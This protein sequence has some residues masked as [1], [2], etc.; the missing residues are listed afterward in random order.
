MFP[1]L[2]L[3]LT[4][5]ASFPIINRIISL[6]VLP[7]RDNPIST[8]VFLLSR[9]IKRSNLFTISSSCCDHRSYLAFE[10]AAPHATYASGWSSLSRSVHA[11]S[12][13]RSFCLARGGSAGRKAEGKKKKEKKD[14]SWQKSD[15]GGIISRR[16]VY[17][18]KVH[19]AKPPAEKD[20]PWTGADRSDR[21]RAQ[22]APKKTR[23][24]G[25]KEKQ[26]TIS[27]K[28]KALSPAPSC[29]TPHMLL[30]PQ[31]GIRWWWVERGSHRLGLAEVSSS[32]RA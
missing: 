23:K 6:F 17:R 22:L 14:E 12:P 11:L 19:T 16:R 7:S 30:R 28:P 15:R 2:L 24:K 31:K 1:S 10:R 25:K 20:C 13:V 32:R 4:R 3:S 18:F 8:L 26:K 29:A 5:Y 21:P 27:Q 9:D